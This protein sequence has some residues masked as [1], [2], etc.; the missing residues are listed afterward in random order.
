MDFDSPQLRRVRSLFIAIKMLLSIQF[1]FHLIIIMFSIYE[2]KKKWC[3]KVNL[4]WINQTTRWWNNISFRKS[5]SNKTGTKKKKKKKI[6]LIGDD[7]VSSL[8]AVRCVGRLFS[9]Y[10]IPFDQLRCFSHFIRQLW[11]WS[12]KFGQIEFRFKCDANHFVR[13][14]SFHE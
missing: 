14:S 3:F 7:F 8:P 13:L 4:K 9:V 2:T 10:F 1:L 5:V 11:G 6:F 12:L